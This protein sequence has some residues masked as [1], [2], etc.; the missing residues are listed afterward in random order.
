VVAV[1][2]SCSSCQKFSVG[3]RSLNQFTQ[4]LAL[5]EQISIETCQ[6]L[7][8][9]AAVFLLNEQVG[10]FPLQTGIGLQQNRGEDVYLPLKGSI[11]GQV[12]NQDRSAVVS[13]LNQL[14][15]IYMPYLAPVVLAAEN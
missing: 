13:E 14:E 2:N 3:K 5:F 15:E 8:L 7:G 9:P 4:P 11:A 12:L 10:R 1:I 6:I